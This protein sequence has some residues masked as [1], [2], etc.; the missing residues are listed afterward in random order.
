MQ[1]AEQINL[2][3][4]LLDYIDQQYT[5]E[6]DGLYHQPIEEYTS[7]E[8]AQ[9]EQQL[10]FRETPL[11]LG[12]SCDLP[13]PGSY[14]V[15]DLTGI[16]ILLTR[17]KQGEFHAFLNVCR[18]RGSR[19]AEGCGKARLFVCPYHAWAYDHT[20]AL[21]ARP[22][23]E[24]FNGADRERYG[25]TPLPAAERDGFLWVLPT[26]GKVFDVE[27]HLSGLAPELA[28]Y[29][30][31]DFHLFESV[32][33]KRK[34][35][36]K[37]MLDTYLESYHFC[38]LHKNTICSIFYDNLQ[39]F[40]TYGDHFRLVSPRRTISALKEQPKE[41]WDLLPHVVAIYTLFPNSVLV[42]QLDHIELWQIF[43]TAGAPNEAMT[44]LSLYTPDPTLT[45]TAKA[46]WQ[47]NLDLVV[48][49]VEKEDFPLGEGIQKGFYSGAQDH[50]VFGRNEPGLAHFHKGITQQVNAR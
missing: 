20:G 24:A 14:T 39:T 25:L 47:K 5:A 46:H 50:I 23:D 40:D 31:A 16:P 32:E 2:G 30:L 26:P 41:T 19:V 22:A 4:R 1:H 6:Q 33:I 35:N 34:L 42:W 45:D 29:N 38:V 18:H 13:E 15:H 17:D 37:L 27:D 12:L 8:R 48:E 10:F 36:W 3:G 21:V 11:C 9:I 49:V 28:A 44:R 7:A 43:P